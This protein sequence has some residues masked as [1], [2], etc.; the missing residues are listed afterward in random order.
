MK[1]SVCAKNFRDFSEITCSM[2]NDLVHKLLLRPVIKSVY[3]SLNWK[4]GFGYIL[5]LK[6]IKIES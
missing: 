3:M 5:F 6:V 2:Q 4:S 1:T